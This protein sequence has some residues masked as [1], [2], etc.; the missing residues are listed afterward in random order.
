MMRRTK[1]AKTLVEDVHVQLRSD[2]LAGR[3][4]P[5][6]RLKMADT[7][8]ELQVSLS[9]LREALA[10]LAEQNLVVL[11]P[12]AGYRVLPLSREDLLDL[13]TARVQIETVA[14][15]QAISRGDLAWEAQVIACHHTLSRTP[16]HTA[17]D[18]D[19]P[20]E[21]WIQAHSEFHASMLAGCGSRRLLAIATSLRETAEVYRKWS[22]P[23]GHDRRRDIPGEHRIILE[24]TLARDA[25]RAVALYEGH[26]EH[27]TKALLGFFD[28]ERPSHEGAGN[29][30]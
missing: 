27:T 29:I 28:K 16:F 19:H 21:A 30:G 14:L 23:L 25:D 13:T 15:R 9:V 4:L 11:E 5:G 7:A 17:D 20:N 24:A 18:P 26:V 1:V 10:R 6:S 2:I 8:A 12:Q 22:L 3:L